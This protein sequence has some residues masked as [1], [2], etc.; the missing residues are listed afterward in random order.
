[1]N[2][3]NQRKIAIII[4]ISVVTVFVILLIALTVNLV[5]L[6]N[7][8]S[9]KADLEAQDAKLAQMIEENELA[10]NEHQTAAW[11]EQYA[12]DYLNMIGGDEIRIE[13]KQ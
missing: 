12:R 11:I 6:A 1:M 4:T 3:Q 10:M 13:V 5:Q 9:R 2:A 8:S 7:A